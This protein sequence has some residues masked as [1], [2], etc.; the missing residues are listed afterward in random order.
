MATV[1]P[2]ALYGVSPAEPQQT[3]FTVSIA[4]GGWLDSSDAG[5]GRVSPC[6]A[7][8]FATKP[9]TLAESLK[10]SRGNMRW[11]MMTDS[12]G[13][14]TNFKIHNIITTYASDA[15]DTPIGTLA[16]GLVFENANYIPTA[17]TD[18]DSSA[19]ATKAL[20]IKD[21]IGEALNSAKTENCLVYDP[22]LSGG[23]MVRESSTT[24]VSVTAVHGTPGT[25]VSGI[26]VTEVTGFAPNTSGQL[27]TDTA[28]TY[29]AE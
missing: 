23:V 22:T 18:I 27:A 13:T 21:K 25:I 17:G 5:G 16:F 24:A 2:K 11:K 7:S 19:Y 8:D 29:S 4:Q 1:E 12:I 26:T 10:V 9:T 3:Y 6:V 14:R 28:L 20:W 15:G